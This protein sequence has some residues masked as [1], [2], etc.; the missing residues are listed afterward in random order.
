MVGGL[1]NHEYPFPPKVEEEFDSSMPYNHYQMKRQEALKHTD[2]QLFTVK[3]ED[4]HPEITKEMLMEIYTNFGD[5]ASIYQPVDLQHN[6]RPLGLAFI[7]YTTRSAAEQAVKETNGA[8]L[9]IGR[10]LI[11]SLSE[12]RSYFSQNESYYNPKKWTSTHKQ[13]MA[14]DL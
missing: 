6:C 2:Q 7:R 14:F 13:A 8:N 10:D 11:V 3:V 12:N 4:I 9:G 5:V 1:I